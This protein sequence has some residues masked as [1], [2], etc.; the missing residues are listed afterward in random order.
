M[1][2]P[3]Q[4]KKFTESVEGQSFDFEIEMKRI[5]DSQQKNSNL[6]HSISSS[7]NK[8]KFDEDPA[9]LK[10]SKRRGNLSDES[11]DSFRELQL[12]EI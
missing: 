2:S 9:G 6:K 4:N 8:V 10:S 12:N 7:Q 5:E 11:F 1:S 3:K